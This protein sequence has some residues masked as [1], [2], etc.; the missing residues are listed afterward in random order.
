MMAAGL[1]RPH[2]KVE[3]HIHP[4]GARRA[5]FGELIQI[6]GSDHAWF[7]GRG[8]QCTLIVFID[9]ASSF[10]TSLLFA[11]SEN[12]LSYM[13]AYQQHIERYGVP[14]ASYSDRHVVSKSNKWNQ[15]Q[16]Q[17]SRNLV[18]LYMN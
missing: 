16:E 10:I 18:E 9:D 6:D 1:W 13:Q 7:E 2:I 5:S 4:T 15:N 11:E 3:P 8:P 14:R 17:A 12:T